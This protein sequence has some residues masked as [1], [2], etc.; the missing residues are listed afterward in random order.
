MSGHRKEG[1]R[2]DRRGFRPSLDGT[3][4]ESRLLLT[5]AHA[6]FIVNQ[7][8]L[9]NPQAGNAFKVGKPPFLQ[10]KIA[11]SPA[12]DFHG[13]VYTRGYATVETIR[14]GQGVQI[15]TPD[16]SHFRVL[17]TL[18]DSQYD[19]PLQA[20]TGSSGANVIPSNRIQGVGTVRAYPMPGGK[21]G[22]I[23]DGSTDNMQLV[24]DPLPFP[25]RKG[26][27]HSFAYGQTGREHLLDIGSLNVT[28][29]RINAILGFHTA[30]LSGPLVIG[31]GAVVD[32]IAVDSIQPG[33]AIGIGG[34]LNTLDVLKGITLTS[35]PGISIANDLNLLNVGQNVVLSNGASLVVGRFVG[36]TPQPPKGTSTGSNVLSL[37]QSQIGSGTSQVISSISSYVQGDFTIGAG[38]VFKVGSGI[39]S[40]S[41]SG[42]STGFPTPVLINGALIAASPTSVNIP[43][44]SANNSFFT[45][46][47]A[48]NLVARNGIYVAGVQIVPPA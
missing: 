26:Y 32:R 43:H 35:G 31:G 5:G 9:T 29:G 2:A 8:L 23:V 33:G 16:G 40:S 1:R 42:G 38:S 41:I 4:L 44:L 20:Q 34:S 24:I 46:G 13:P 22:I 25:Q 18:A 47:V 6:P 37:N 10:G 36:L 7:F 14:G 17:L 48:N 19:G 28:S 45:S 11:T 27:A 39:A 3:T 21:V 15:A 30:D 12:K